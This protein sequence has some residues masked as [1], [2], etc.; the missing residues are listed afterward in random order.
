MNKGLL[1]MNGYVHSTITYNYTHRYTYV[2]RLY[3]CFSK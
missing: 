3:V 1:V 2:V